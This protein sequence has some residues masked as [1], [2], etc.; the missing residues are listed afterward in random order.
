MRTRSTR[1]KVHSNGTRAYKVPDKVYFA[2]MADPP[3]PTR[4]FQASFLASGLAEVL[5]TPIDVV[6]VRLQVQRSTGAATAPGTT[7]TGMIDAFVKISKHEG[8]V[9][10][11]K[12]IIPSLLRQTSYTSLSMV[13]YEPIRNTFT[14]FS[15]DPNNPGFF[16]RL[17]AGGTAGG[18]G[19]AVM[20][21][22]EVVKTK[23]QASQLQRRLTIREVIS[24]VWKKEGILGFW[25]G[26]KPNVVRTFL[27]NAAEL[28]T[29]DQAKHFLSQFP[30]FPPGSLALHVSASSFAGVCSAL[31]STPADVIKTRLMNQ[32]GKTH[33]YSGILHAMVE[34]PRRE[35]FL[36]LYKGVGP[37]LVRKIVWVT[38]FF[39]MYERFYVALS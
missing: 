13:L 19:I 24:E 26:V 3:N 4:R 2:K 32:A 30:L 39:V 34:I 11:F 29:Y 38:G 35:G 1:A 27:V 5:T 25:S 18:I 15:S 37:I 9:G 8:P 36:S 21:P 7:Y 22:T 23:M 16:L 10:L 31:T 28:G 17:L 20:N 6:K 12:G 33:E 14:S